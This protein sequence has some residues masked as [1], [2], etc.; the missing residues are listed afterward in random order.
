MK[1]KLNRTGKNCTVIDDYGNE[2]KYLTSI[3][4]KTSVGKMTTVVLQQYVEP[5]EVEIEKGSDIQIEQMCCF[6]GQPKP[7]EE[8]HD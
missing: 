1:I 3:E 7:K 6:C 5:T 2:I 8:K 4:I